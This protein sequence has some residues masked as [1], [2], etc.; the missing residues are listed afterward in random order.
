VSS[1]FSTFSSGLP[2]WLREIDRIIFRANNDA[3]K[4]TKEFNG[5]Y[6][7]WT[8]QFW[9]DAFGLFMQKEMERFVRFIVQKLKDAELFASQGGPVILTQVQ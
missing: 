2:Y 3:Y 1:V 8:E 4:V 5:C 9:T 6:K 7:T